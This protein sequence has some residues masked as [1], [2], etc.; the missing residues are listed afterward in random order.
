MSCA[1]VEIVR[2]LRATRRWRAGWI[3]PYTGDPPLRWARWTW[4]VSDAAA[5]IPE[6][7]SRFREWLLERG[8]SAG[9]PDVVATNGAD[10]VVIECKRQPMGGSKDTPRLTQTGWLA[11]VLAPRRAL[12]ADDDFLVAYWER[13]PAPRTPPRVPPEL[14]PTRR[15]PKGRPLA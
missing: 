7:N 4:S 3:S 12:L 6:P 5:A 2:R 14:E 8:T 1:E 9:T 10:L 13:T 11:E 15:Y